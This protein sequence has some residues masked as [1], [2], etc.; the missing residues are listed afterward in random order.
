MKR[1]R[2]W[3]GVDVGARKKGFHVAVVSTSGI[4]ARFR[5]TD[6]AA[7]AAFLSEQGPRVVAVDSPR[8]PARP[9]QRS[10][11]DERALVRAGVC[12][13]RFIPDHA[14]LRSHPRGFYDWVLNGFALYEELVA[15]PEARWAVI[16]CFP[17]ASFTRIG[18]PRGATSRA[19]WSRDVLA[20]LGFDPLG[21]QDE[22]DAVMA[23]LTARIYDEDG[24]ERFGEIFVPRPG[25]LITV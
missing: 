14:T 3:A 8:S 22:R 7:V 2:R 24:C 15:A 20:R 1:A 17:T 4:E 5:A 9:R 10:R 23:A 13:I 25:A 12:G 19:A 16:E 21:N 6:P 18:G 11:E